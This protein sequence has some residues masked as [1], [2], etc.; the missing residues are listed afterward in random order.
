MRIKKIYIVL[1][2]A[3]LLTSLWSTSGNFDVS[4]AHIRLRVAHQ[5]V[6]E[7]HLVTES[8]GDPSSPSTFRDRQGTY[9]SQYGLGQSVFFLPFDALATLVTSNLSLDTEQMDRVR[10]F[11]VS[12]PVFWTVLALNFWLCL[13]LSAQLGVDRLTAYLVS[14]VATFGSSFWE[15]AKTGQEEVQLSILLL[16]SLSGFLYWKKS[17]ANKYVWLS[18]TLAAIT[19]IFR[20]TALPIFVGIATLYAYEVFHHKSIKQSRFSDLKITIPFVSIAVAGIAI[21]GGYNFL[22]TGNILRTG[23]ALKGWF[24]NHDW[25]T[26]MTQ[27]VLGLDKGIILT[28]IWFLPCLVLTFFA[29]RHLK[30]EL[31]LL[32]LLSLFLYT[33]SVAIYAKCCWASDVH[34]GVR[35]QVHVVPLLCLSLGIAALTYIKS[36]FSKKLQRKK[37][38][39]LAL[40]FG[41]TLFGLQLP[42]ISLHF[43]L[44]PFQARAS[45]TEPLNGSVTGRLGQVRLRYLNFGS[46]LV[47]GKPVNLGVYN[48]SDNLPELLEKASRWNFWP[49]SVQR[50]VRS[51]VF[52]LMQLTWLAMIL[53]SLVSW[54]Y[55]FWK[56]VYG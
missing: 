32:L 14:F 55:V 8:T 5:I 16:G 54:G 27:P 23:Y 37:Y 21:I 12:V 6:T 43:L 25:L 46:K 28:N 48:T 13:K 36:H 19:L 18:A 29:W 17:G 50:Y 31:K 49:W 38:K 53:G 2:L 44:E 10:V 4:D 41:V 45:N 11:L 15:M 40:F 56:L 52:G 9:T 7:G 51:N 24:D 1:F 34:Y 30:H 42:S 26:G 3:I 39:L 33:S 22:K 47:T 20:V 35:Y